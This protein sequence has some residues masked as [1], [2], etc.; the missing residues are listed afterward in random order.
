[1]ITKRLITP[2]ALLALAFSG[3]ALASGK[4]HYDKSFRKGGGDGDH[5]VFFRMSRGETVTLGKNGP[6]RLYAECTEDSGAS[7]ITL[8]FVSQE[9][10]SSWFSAFTPPSSVAN[11][12]DKDVPQPVAR[13]QLLVPPF[14][15]FAPV[16]PAGAVSQNGRF[17]GF[18]SAVFLG[19]DIQGS[20]CTVVGE[21]IKTRER[22]RRQ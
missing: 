14:R 1:M 16:Q 10:N 8:Y 4:T 22:H 7:V 13:L 17:I 5:N 15:P 11:V 20:D 12:L 21:I 3:S 18:S 9:D 2:L 19:V 6:L